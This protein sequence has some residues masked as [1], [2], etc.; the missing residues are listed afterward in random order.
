VKWKFVSSTSNC[1]GF[2]DHKHDTIYIYVTE[3]AI[4]SGIMEALF[5][6]PL[7]RYAT[8]LLIRVSIHEL[9]H[10][11]E[12]D[13]TMEYHSFLNDIINSMLQDDFSDIISEIPL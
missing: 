8:Y 13:L 9:A 4:I 10:R 1:Y 5:G 7:Q 3:I 12:L 6:I 2:Y 11:L